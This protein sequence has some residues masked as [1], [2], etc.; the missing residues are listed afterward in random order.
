MPNYLG[1]KTGNT[2]IPSLLISTLQKVKDP[3]IQT[4]LYQ[5][6]NWANSF[7]QLVGAATPG[8]TLAGS[9][10]NQPLIVSAGTLVATT[11]TGGTAGQVTLTF[12]TAFPNGLVSVVA[13]SGDQAAAGDMLVVGNQSGSPA[14]RSAIVLICLNAGPGTPISGVT[15]RINWVAVG[16]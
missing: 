8:S 13:I 9:W 10:T 14:S 11:G 16:F 3:H 2:G 4:A 12:P 7:H 6:Q 1:T 15:V 5:I